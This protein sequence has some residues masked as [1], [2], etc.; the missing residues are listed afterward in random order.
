MRHIKLVLAALMVLGPMAANA[1]PIFT[2]ASFETGNSNGWTEVNPFQGGVNDPSLRSWAIGSAM[3]GTYAVWFGALDNAPGSSYGQTLGGFTVGA[4]YTVS[5]GMVPEQASNAPRD[6]TRTVATALLSLIGADVAS[7]SFAADCANPN[8]N[9]FFGCA[10]GWQDMS[11]TFT[12][13]AP[14]IDFTWTADLVNSPRSWEFGFDNVRLE[15]VPEPGTLALLGIGLA[16]MG[17]ARRRR[18]V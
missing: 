17:L 5:F 9:T 10:P 15:R 4:M 12:A 7:Q 18:K 14:S 8:D 11:L 6:V 16:G 13:L 1:V 3:D 2:N